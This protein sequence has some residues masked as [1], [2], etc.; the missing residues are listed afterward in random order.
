MALFLFTQPA[1]SYHI[2]SSDLE[3]YQTHFHSL[4][5]IFLSY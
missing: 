2:Y 5:L 3:Y 1:K 4:V